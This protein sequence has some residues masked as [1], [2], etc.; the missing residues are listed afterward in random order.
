MFQKLSFLLIFLC[1]ISVS[2]FASNTLVEKLGY[3]T[4]YEKAVKDAIESHK[5]VMMVIGTTTCPW[6]KKFENQVL[7]KNN[8]NKIVQTSFTPLVLNK[9]HDHYPKDRFV[10]KGVPTTFFINP[11]S[12][13]LIHT[14]E[15][16]K[17]QN[18]FIK[19]LETAKNLYYKGKQP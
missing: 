16:Y 5:P 13:E 1:S 19:E 14:V 11:L 3:L 2:L 7:Q 12:Y 18:Q 4:N 10:A 15:G 8:I 6:C 17:H 9:D